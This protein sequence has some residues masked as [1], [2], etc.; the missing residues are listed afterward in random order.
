M[1]TM[2][3]GKIE[4]VSVDHS[5]NIY[6][7]IFEN[8][9]DAILITTPDGG[10]Q[11]AN[12]AACKMFGL[13][14]KEIIKNGR[15]KLLDLSD[16]SISQIVAE[17]TRTESSK[18]EVNHKRKDGTVFPA[19][20]STSL[21]KDSKGRVRSI[22]IINDIT[23][24]MLAKQTIL[25]SEERFK[26]L[27]NL[28]PAGI[29][30]TDEAG[31]CTFVNEAWCT[32]AGMLPEEAYGDGWINAIHPNDR[33]HIFNIWDIY[34]N[35]GK[36][37]N[38]DYRFLDKNGK[39]TWVYGLTKPILD[40]EGKISGFLGTNTD[41]T[42]NKISEDAL[43]ESEERF[44]LLSEQSG[45]GVAL[46]SPEGKILFFNQ[47]ALKNLGGKSE[48][49]IG[50]S[51]I[52][53]FGR[54]AGTKYLKRVREEIRLEKNII[55]EDYFESASGKYWFSSSHSV[56]SNS[57]GEIIGVQVV[58][59][60]ISERKIIESRLN[61]SANE[62]RGLTR[63]LV[64]VKEAERTRIAH[65]LHD[66]LGQKLTALNMDLS[67]LK[68]RIGVQSRN[69]ENKLKQMVSLMNE[70][71]E[72][73]QKI[74]HGLRPSI[75]DDLGLLPAIEWLI[76]E[77][78]KNTGISCSISYSPNEIQVDAG[79]SLVVFRIVQET[80]TNITRHSGATK[81]SIRIKLIDKNLDISIKDNGSGI[82]QEKIDSSRS[83]GLVGM[84]ERVR[85]VG[86]EINITGKKGEGTTVRVM[87][88]VGKG[89]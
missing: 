55:Y 50:K 28:S 66:D 51:L 73:V 81:V 4:G 12:P 71:I 58:S 69:V 14:E 19:E 1:K 43:R 9:I 53:V 2:K 78:H 37:W 27:V 29:Y 33:E 54:K 82:D 46:Y 49:F 59:N 88:A 72:S 36:E 18:G 7:A 6:K 16:V 40:S 65:D 20:I 34:V 75:L 22:V 76:I 74:S 57:K 85:A 42:E 11:S 80:L 63:H 23:E 79:I 84:R 68:S 67:W 13:T 5:E 3:R 52:E 21:F 89:H 41:I 83:F 30:L 8:S 62:L 39:V 45:L 56:V 61:Q 38:W 24:R 31:K 87:I 32:M 70:T 48:D 77:F 47:R 25:K 10:I 26:M 35:T 15:D 17:R 44:R 86:G 64:E 60:D